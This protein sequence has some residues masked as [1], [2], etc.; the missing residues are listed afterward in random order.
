MASTILNSSVIWVQ[1]AIK[2]KSIMVY[3]AL[4]SEKL[5]NMKGSS[6][7]IDWSYMITEGIKIITPKVYSNPKSKE[8]WFNKKKKSIHVRQ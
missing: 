8:I 3:K 4:C 1:S 6:K 5:N 7:I 2:L